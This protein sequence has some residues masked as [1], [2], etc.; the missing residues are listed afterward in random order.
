MKERLQKLIFFLLSMA[1]LFLI[2]RWA[3]EIRDSDSPYIRFPDKIDTF[4]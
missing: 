2:I 1:L 4:K 3:L